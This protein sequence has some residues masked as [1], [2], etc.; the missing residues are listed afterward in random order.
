MEIVCALTGYRGFESLPLRHFHEKIPEKGKPGGS[1][2]VNPVRPEREQ[3][4]QELTGCPVSLAG[5]IQ[6]VPAFF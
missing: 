6:I 3:R 4:Y 5:A 1:E 2:P